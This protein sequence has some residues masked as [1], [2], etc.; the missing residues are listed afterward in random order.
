MQVTIFLIGTLTLS[1]EYDVQLTFFVI[2]IVEIFS[3]YLMNS[4]Y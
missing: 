1:G 3:L 2:L 4:I